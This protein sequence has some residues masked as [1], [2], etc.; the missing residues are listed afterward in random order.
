MSSETALYTVW[1]K[2]QERRCG[3]PHCTACEWVQRM[4][5]YTVRAEDRL[6]AFRAGEEV[7]ARKGAKQPTAYG[8]I[9]LVVT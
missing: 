8:A 4:A 6:G 7:A 9:R 3:C 2:W 5:T 1:V